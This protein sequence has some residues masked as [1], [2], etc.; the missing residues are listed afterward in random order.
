L[1]IRLFSN[2]NNALEP[3]LKIHNPNPFPWSKGRFQNSYFAGC[4]HPSRRHA[5]TESKS[6]R[7]A[8]P[9]FYTA[10]TGLS[11]VVEDLIERGNDVN[12]NSSLYPTPCHVAVLKRNVKMAESILHNG[13]K[14][15]QQHLK[16]GST[17]CFGFWGQP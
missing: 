14:V 7:V 15:D 8:S 11:W 13:G 12:Q 1:I 17:D 2:D 3:W 6:S 4:R 16:A 10:A 9:I 5:G